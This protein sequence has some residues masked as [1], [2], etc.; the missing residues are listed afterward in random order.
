[1]LHRYLSKSERRKYMKTRKAFI[2][3]MLAGLFLIGCLGVTGS[4]AVNDIIT[5]LKAQVG[6]QVIKEHIVQK[7][8]T[9]DLTTDDIVKLKKAGASDD[10]LTFMLQGASGDFPFELEEGLVVE[11]PVI[12]H[13]LALYPVVRTSSVDVGDYITLEMAQTNKTVLI[14]E[15]PDASVPTVLIRNTG[16]R[17][18]YIMAGE[19]IIGGKQDRMVSFDIIIP[20]GKEIEVE[21]RCVE[22]G[23][24]H[25]ASVQFSPGGAVGSK[26]VRTALQFKTQHDVWDEVEKMCE[27]HDIA[28]SSGTY[29]ALLSSGEVDKKSKP[30]LDAMNRGL[31]NENMVGLIMALNGEIVCVD[32][33]MNPEYFAQVKEKLLKAY[34]LD[35]ISTAEIHAGAADKQKIISFFNELNRAQRAELKEYRD[36]SNYE[37]ESDRIIGNESRDSDGRLQ[38]LN[39]Y[40]K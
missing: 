5:L 24:W 3:S 31:Q 35:A 6:E 8:Y 19:I 11:Q 12:C 21:V 28:S 34:V 7:E 32:I 39:L 40:M 29:G 4:E 13:H 26:K 2:L 22:H 16:K 36:N 25:G 10:L 30:F 27:E 33:F 37:L 1:M 20:T 14:K 38:H 18:I 23:R 17:P 15:K 9:F